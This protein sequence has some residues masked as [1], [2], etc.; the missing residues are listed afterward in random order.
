[1]E[2]KYSKQSIK[3]LK[4]QGMPARKCISPKNWDNI[5]SVEPDETDLHMLQEIETDPECHEF[6][7]SADAMKE[8]GL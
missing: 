8:L 4:K 5:E 3:F 6:I 2:I 1:M 7:S